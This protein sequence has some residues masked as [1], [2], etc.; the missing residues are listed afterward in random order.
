M[1]GKSVEARQLM[2]M[3]H[4]SSLE[5]EDNE[6]QDPQLLENTKANAL[7]NSGSPHN[8]GHG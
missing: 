6:V 3:G 8:H 5:E 2:A 4:G 7:V 1:F